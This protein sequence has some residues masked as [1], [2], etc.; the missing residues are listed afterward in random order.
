MQI[1]SVRAIH[2]GHRAGSDIVSTCTGNP[3]SEVDIEQIKLKY[4]SRKCTLIIS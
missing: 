1:L 3:T 4:P 2:S